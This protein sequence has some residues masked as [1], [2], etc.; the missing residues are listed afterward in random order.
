MPCDGGRM[1]EGIPAGSEGQDTPGIPARR[2]QPGTA[3]VKSE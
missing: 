1:E 2:T 3:E